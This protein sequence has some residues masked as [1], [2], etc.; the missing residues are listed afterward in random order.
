MPQNEI[1]IS[2]EFITVEEL[3]FRDQSA[4]SSQLE[5]LNVADLDAWIQKEDSTLSLAYKN[6]VGADLLIEEINYAKAIEYLDITIDTDDK[7]YLEIALWNKALCLVLA[8][9]SSSARKILE[10]FKAGENEL[11]KKAES[12]LQTID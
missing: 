4:T 11:S 3:S 10:E 6:L 9:E 5:D 7:R 2:N 8:G 1:N 12:I